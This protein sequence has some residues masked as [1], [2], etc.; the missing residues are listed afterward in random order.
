MLYSG[1]AA[2]FYFVV[3]GILVKRL[4]CVCRDN[5]GFVTFRR[6]EDAYRAI[7]SEIFQLVCAF[8]FLFEDCL[9]LCMM[10]S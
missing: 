10:V 6:T 3:D 1:V 8:V 4:C 2:T 9:G 7:E 5:Y